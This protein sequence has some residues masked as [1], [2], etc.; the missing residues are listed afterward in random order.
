M[1]ISFGARPNFIVHPHDLNCLSTKLLLGAGTH[2]YL[3]KL[4]G[5]CSRLFTIGFECPHFLEFTLTEVNAGRISLPLWRVI[6]FELPNARHLQALC[7]DFVDCLV[8]YEKSIEPE[9]LQIIFNE[10]LISSELLL[11]IVQLHR[12]FIMSR[13]RLSNVYLDFLKKNEILADHSFL[14]SGISE[15]LVSKDDIEP[16]EDL[17]KKLKHLRILVIYSG[18][19]RIGEALFRGITIWTK[20]ERFGIDN[21]SEQVGQ[22]QL[23]QMPGYW[24]NLKGLMLGKKPEDLKFVTE[25]KNLRTLSIR[26]NLPREET[27]F[28]MRTCPSLYHMAFHNKST[29]LFNFLYTRN[30][31][32]HAKFFKK[33]FIYFHTLSISYKLVQYRLVDGRECDHNFRLFNSLDQLLDHYYDKDIFNKQEISSSKVIKDLFKLSLWN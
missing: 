14:F 18:S 15:L 17:V 27:L 16:D 9:S 24:P 33:I 20:L 6:K 2:D 13:D 28:L 22:H 8:Q 4:F 3:R 29:D 31:Y 30:A 32:K 11:S 23:D 25:F 1:C 10:E 19:S 26:F 21:F 12:S 5:Q 7:D